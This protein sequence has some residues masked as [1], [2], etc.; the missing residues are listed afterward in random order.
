MKIYTLTGDDGTT[1]LAGGK[2]VPKHSLRIEAYGTVDELISWIGLLRS[3]K[4]NDKRK[5]ILVY[6]QGQLMY[7]A[8][9]VASANKKHDSG[10]LLP[11]QGCL[12]KI[13]SEIDKMEAELKPIKSFVLPGGSI[14]V[15]HCHIARTVCRRAERAVLRLRE[16][17]Y[18]PAIVHK[19]LN[20]LSDYLFVLSRKLSLELDNEEIKW[21]I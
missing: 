6:V 2:R 15:S 4:E 9:A 10:L 13:E 14:I 18:T 8:A 20:R 21:P 12:A 17:E 16:T 19:L 7:A 1:S 11:E 5:E 3:H